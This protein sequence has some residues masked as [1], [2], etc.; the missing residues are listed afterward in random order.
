MHEMLKLFH[1]KLASFGL[2][3]KSNLVACNLSPKYT[4]R[5]F[6]C[7]EMESECHLFWRCLIAKA[8]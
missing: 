4:D 7:D 6:G 5:L 2:P 3:M 8:L 1:W